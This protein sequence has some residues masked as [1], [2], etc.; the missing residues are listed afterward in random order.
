MQAEEDVI[1]VDRVHTVGVFEEKLLL[2]G[3]EEKL[4]DEEK[5]SHPGALDGL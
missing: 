5:H 1:A 2:L 3:G 4:R